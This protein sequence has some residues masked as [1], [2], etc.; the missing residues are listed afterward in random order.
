MTMAHER[1]TALVNAVEFLRELRYASDTPVGMREKL[2]GIL[3]HLPA[4]SNWKRSANFM[5]GGKQ[6]GCCRR[7]FTSGRTAHL[8]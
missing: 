5:I 6:L 8:C 1:T 2:I 4:Q 7:I 3:R